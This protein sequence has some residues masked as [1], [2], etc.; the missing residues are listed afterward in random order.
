M[1]TAAVIGLK[2]ILPPHYSMPLRLALLVLSGGVAYIIVAG[3]LSYSRR[4]ALMRA[5]NLLRNRGSSP[6]I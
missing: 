4:H 2:D 6:G 1:M 5:I 3:S